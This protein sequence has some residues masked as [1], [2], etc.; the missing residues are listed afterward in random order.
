MKDKQN[1]L[2]ERDNKNEKKTKRETAKDLFGEMRH[3]LTQMFT[4][5]K[6]CMLFQHIVEVSP[7]QRRYS[8][9]EPRIKLL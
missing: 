4:D 7:L 3:K 6:V 9:Y 8:G 5:L 2:K 1:M